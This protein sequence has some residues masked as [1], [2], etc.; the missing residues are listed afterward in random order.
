MNY[1]SSKNQAIKRKFVDRE[2]VECVSMLVSEIAEKAE[3]FPDYQ[4]DLCGAFE[5]PDYEASIENHVADMD[6]DECIEYLEGLSIE[7]RDD[8]TTE[9]LR[10]AV[11][12][13]AIEEGAEY[14]CNEH[15]ID[16]EFSEIFEHWIITEWLA[17]KLEA[18]GEKVLRDFFGLTIWGRAC[19]G[20]AILLDPVISE[21]CDEMEILEGQRN[22]WG[23]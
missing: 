17:D 10:A 16:I 22:E 3:C 11:V 5:V 14:F 9:T 8:E 4:E 13:N 19:T 1:N 15:S 6:R 21:I 18:K 23:V 20:Q 7:C 2:V 12:A